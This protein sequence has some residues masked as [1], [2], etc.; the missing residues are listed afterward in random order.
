MNIDFKDV[1]TQVTIG[2]VVLSLA[3]AA[4]FYFLK[5]KPSG[6]YINARKVKLDSL[7]AG[8]RLLDAAVSESTRLN[9]ELRNMSKKLRQAEKLLPDEKDIPN[10]LRQITQA[11]IKTGVRFTVFKPGVLSSTPEAKL[12][13]MLLVD[14]S[15]TGTYAQLGDFMANLGTINRIVVPAKLKVTPITSSNEK[16]QTIKADFIVKAFVFNKVGGAK[17]DVTNRGKPSR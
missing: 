1:K 8:I 10:L 12:S 5:F 11:G 3:I 2:L 14:I 4:L 16:R 9:M 6:E 17:S 15:I 13:S 7:E